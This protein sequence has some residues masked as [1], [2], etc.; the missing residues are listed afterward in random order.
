MASPVVNTDA[1]VQS[2]RVSCPTRSYLTIATSRYNE[3]KPVS[4]PLVRP[5]EPGH[6]T[7][8]TDPVNDEDGTDKRPGNGQGRGTIPKVQ[9]PKKRCDSC[10]KYFA[11]DRGVNIHK[12]KM[13]KDISAGTQKQRSQDTP[14]RKTRENSSP[15]IHH[16]TQELRVTVA[17]SNPS[18]E[19]HLQE[20]SAYRPRPKLHWPAATDKRWQELD[21]DLEVT[22]NASLRVSQNGRWNR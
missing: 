6:E 2:A 3:N 14:R 16:S 20:E 10:G 11:G 1:S 21:D 12:G 19:N 22:L 17:P 9:Q 15:E 4:G 13:H 5:N 8:S 7:R 18:P